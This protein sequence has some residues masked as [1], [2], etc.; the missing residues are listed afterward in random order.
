MNNYR[1]THHY[2]D[3]RADYLAMAD[4]FGVASDRLLEQMPQS[5]KPLWV[6]AS[7]RLPAEVRSVL[8][9]KRTFDIPKHRLAAFGY[10]YEIVLDRGEDADENGV[11]AQG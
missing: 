3:F 2:K 6:R 5:Y 10:G 4:V 9:N 7:V 11:P 8:L 1:D